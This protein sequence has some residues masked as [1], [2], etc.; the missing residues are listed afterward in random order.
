MITR[1]QQFSPHKSRLTWRY[2]YSI[3][4]GQV[5]REPRLQYATI[6]EE[7]QNHGAHLPNLDDFN[8][9]GD[10][11]SG[12]RLLTGRFTSWQWV[13]IHFLDELLDWI[14]LYRFYFDPHLLC[15]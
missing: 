7:L 15:E 12:A 10:R 6:K 2:P 11:V 9:V 8:C 3:S 5:Y 1:I 4:T 14:Y 13:S